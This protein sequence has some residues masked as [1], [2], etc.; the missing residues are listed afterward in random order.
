MTI[1][2]VI[3]RESAAKDLWPA[4]PATAPTVARATS[5]SRAFTLLTHVVDDAIEMERDLE[6]ALSWD[7]TTSSFAQA[8][9][10]FWQ[11][12]LQQTCDIFTTPLSSAADRPLQRM[13]MLLHFLIESESPDE[14]LRLQELLQENRELFTSEDPMRHASLRAA[15]RQVN[16]LVDLALAAE[17]FCSLP[18]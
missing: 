8:A 6:N 9:E 14:A 12:C 15:E 5:I 7:P 2:P 4:L 18:G 10:T 1:A 13:A 3:T 17:A 11:D 16:T